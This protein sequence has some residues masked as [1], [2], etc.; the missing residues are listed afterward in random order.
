MQSVDRAMT[1]ENRLEVGDSSPAESASA[2]KRAFQARKIPLTLTP[3]RIAS[4]STLMDRA[5]NAIAPW[6]RRDYPGRLRAWVEMSGQMPHAL[7]D[8]RRGRRGPDVATVERVLA[9]IESRAAILNALADSL[10]VERDRLR[11][12]PPRHTGAIAVDSVSG[13]DARYRGKKTKVHK[14]HI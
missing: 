1:D 4:G 7:K 12:I 10:R 2:C 3:V 5:L 9:A 13:H 8:Y 11:S 6:Y 14:T